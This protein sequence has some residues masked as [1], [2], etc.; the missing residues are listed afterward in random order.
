MSSA[1][2][3]LKSRFNCFWI[4]NPKE[5][6]YFIP[7]AGNVDV[8]A[9]IEKIKADLEYAKGSLAIANKKLSNE[10]FV[11]GAPEQ[12]VA[13]EQKKKADAEAKTKV[14]EEQLASLV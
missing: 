14:L 11:A 2:R 9:E 7:L 8:E 6:G 10:K 4:S 3:D 13:A 12:V 5:Q 1:N